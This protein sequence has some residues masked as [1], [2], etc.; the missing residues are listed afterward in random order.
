MLG[1]NESTGVLDPA[2]VEDA[3]KV[4]LHNLLAKPNNNN[5][6]KQGQFRRFFISVFADF[7]YTGLRPG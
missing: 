5:N 2:S 4:A 7:W 6:T 3:R 1:L